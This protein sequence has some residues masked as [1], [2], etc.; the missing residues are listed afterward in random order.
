MSTNVFKLG[1]FDYENNILCSEKFEKK[2][3]SIIKKNITIIPSE[4]L[5]EIYYKL[6]KY[7]E[8]C[9]NEIERSKTEDT[10]GNLRDEITSLRD[11]MNLAF[12]ISTIMINIS[13]FMHLL[14]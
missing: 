1:F 6:D 10:I 14:H 12:M 9:I 5:K 13:L 7:T 3:K 2:V 4:K 11:E 8:K